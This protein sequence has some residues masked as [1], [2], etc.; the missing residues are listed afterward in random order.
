[1][2]TVQECIDAYC[3]RV[4]KAHEQLDTTQLELL[5]NAIEDNLRG[6]YPKLLMWSPEKYAKFMQSVDTSGVDYRD[7]DAVERWAYEDAYDM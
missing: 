5:T 2:F 3:S 7:L 6:R 4:G 1:M